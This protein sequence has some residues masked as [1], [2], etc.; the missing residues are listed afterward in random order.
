MIIFE[1]TQ[2]KK[3]VIK[4]PKQ[5]FKFEVLNFKVQI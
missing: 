3:Q 5:I 4:Y 1:K 2:V